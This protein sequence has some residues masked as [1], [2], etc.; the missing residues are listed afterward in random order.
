MWQR[1][2]LVHQ[3]ASDL[4]VAVR[5]EGGC[6]SAFTL[7]I[8]GYV[9]SCFTRYYG[10][11]G[12]SSLTCASGNDSGAGPWSWSDRSVDSSICR[13]NSS[14]VIA[15]SERRRG[16]CGAW[17]SSLPEEMSISLSE[18]PRALEFEGPGERRR[19]HQDPERDPKPGA[20]CGAENHD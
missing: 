14:S 13:K 6:G 19:W 12:G 7:R 8:G 3:A 20:A 16:C 2:W 15:A 5:V 11:E 17:S 18:E 9:G 4:D 1:R 10:S